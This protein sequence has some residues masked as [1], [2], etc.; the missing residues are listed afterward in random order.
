MKNFNQTYHLM[1]SKTFQDVSPL[2]EEYRLIFFGK[3]LCK[4][5]KAIGENKGTIDI[6][7]ANL[8]NN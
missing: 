6:D 4:L 8:P 1:D 7:E 3:Y 2:F 5:K